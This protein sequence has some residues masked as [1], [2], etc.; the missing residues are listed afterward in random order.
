VS[1]YHNFSSANLPASN[2]QR[3]AN[4]NYTVFLGTTSGWQPEEGYF[5]EITPTGETVATYRAAPGYFVDNHDLILTGSGASQQAHVFTYDVRTKD[6]SPFG[7]P[8]SVVT[9]GHQVV[10]FDA[11]G[12]ED[13]R[14]DAWDHIGLDEWIGD[15]FARASR[16]LTDYDHPNALTF[17]LAGN[18][19]VSWRNLDQITAID[20]ASGA[21]LWRLGGLK[22]EFTFVNDPLDGFSKQHAVKML[23]NGNVLLFDNGTDH[24]P[25]QSRAVEYRLDHVAKTATMVWESR[26]DP[27]LHAAFL[28]WVD[29]LDDGNTWVGYTIFG[30]VQE[31][32]PSGSVVWEGQLQVNGANAS[33]YRIIPVPAIQ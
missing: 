28:G 25:S 12:R 15:G 7:G 1:W 31:V 23:P 20:Q 26:H 9:A 11:A 33:V 17:D 2:L 19:V 5:L 13:F 24:V 4:G 18:Y 27:I 21:F 3:Q 30:R 6:L 14:W 8:S 29:R 16:T 10:R 22:G 32:A